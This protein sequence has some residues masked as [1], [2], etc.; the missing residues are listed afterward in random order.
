MNLNLVKG[1]ELE[2]AVY[3]IESMILEHLKNNPNAQVRITPKHKEVINGVT[4]E[5]DLLVKVEFEKG[6]NSIFIFECKN[7]TSEKVNKNEIIA[8]SEKI[9][10]FSATK[11]FF[12][13]TQ[14]TMDA[15]N[16]SKLDNRIEIKEA[17]AQTLSPLEYIVLEDPYQRKLNTITFYKP[18]EEI[19]NES[20]V[21]D[22]CPEIICGGVVM[23]Y[24]QFVHT[25]INF[26]CTKE[27]IAEHTNESIKRFTAKVNR[28][29]KFKDESLIIGG[30]EH[31]KVQID[32]N[33]T[34]E[35]CVPEIKFGYKV[36]SRGMYIELGGTLESGTYVCIHLTGTET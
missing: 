2:S 36:K 20:L 10:V 32:F 23:D 21:L 33:L 19:G 14:F 6:Y 11:G 24:S 5:I 22:S 35:K 17:S 25:L 13:A 28:V 34:I 30:V 9:K 29:F 3:M 4:H 8:F 1:N 15:I 26:V 7:W 27:F 12:I 16:Q 31:N 18:D